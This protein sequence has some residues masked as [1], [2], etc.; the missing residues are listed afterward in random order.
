MMHVQGNTIDFDTA[1]AKLGTAETTASAR[2]KIAKLGEQFDKV[3]LQLLHSLQTSLDVEQVLGLFFNG[4]QQLL[5][6]DGL[7]YRH[8]AEPSA[9]QLGQPAMHRCS[10][11]ISHARS[12]LG[13]LQ[14]SRQQRFGENELLAIETLLGT[15]LYPLRNALMYRDALRDALNDSL[16]GTSNRLA[17]NQNLER[18]IRQSQ[19][20]QQPLSLLVLD[21]DHFK[22]VNDRYGHA[23]GDAALKAVAN[24]IT[25]SLRSVDGLYRLGGEEF[26]VLLNST[27]L[28]AARMVAERIRKSVENM[29]FELDSQPIPLTVSLGLA[30]LHA[31]DNASSLINRGDHLMYDAKRLGRNRVCVES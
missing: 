13:E 18:D 17:L 31:D 15:L 22:Q 20:S 21:I 28:D 16:T 27:S 29:Q 7:E 2:R 9:C 24:C 19:R 12:Y 8:N 4:V 5:Q 23:Y 1:R 11:R 6:V 14:F 25:D 10:Y 3:Q 26:V 30:T